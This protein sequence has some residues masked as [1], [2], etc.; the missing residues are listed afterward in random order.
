MNSYCEFVTRLIPEKHLE[1]VLGKNAM[2][3]FTRI[4]NNG[5]S[6]EKPLYSP[7]F[8]GPRGRGFE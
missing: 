3:I 7:G 8:K 1:N 2:N 6:S 4:L 5:S